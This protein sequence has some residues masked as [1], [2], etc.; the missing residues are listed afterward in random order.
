[1]NLWMFQ[2]DVTEIPKSI[3]PP[4]H[5]MG[6]MHEQFFS[7]IYTIQEPKHLDSKEIKIKATWLICTNPLRHLDI[8]Q[9]IKRVY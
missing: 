7:C 5:M 8:S 9:M 1:M 2:M 4:L 3:A 6:L